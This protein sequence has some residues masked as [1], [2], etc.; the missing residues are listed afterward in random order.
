MRL[1]AGLPKM[2]WAEAVNTTT[3]LIN[4]GPSIALKFKLLEE[5]WSSKKIDL[6]YLKV[7]GYVSY[8]HIDPTTRTKLDAKSKKCFLL[9]M[10]TLSLA[11][12][13]GMT[14]T[15]KLLRARM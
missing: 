4:R 11:I 1:I 7:F 5:V 6:S 3:Y 15:R 10:V 13:Y 9:V 2:F 14:E 12:T 8:M